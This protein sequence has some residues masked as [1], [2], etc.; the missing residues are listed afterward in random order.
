MTPG[1]LF[2]VSTPIG[3]LED[4]SLRAINCLKSCQGIAC[5]D[6]RVTQKLLNRYAI[7]QKLVSYRDAN[8]K[9]KALELLKYLQNGETWALVSDAGTPLINDPGFCLVRACKENNIPVVPIPGPCALIAALSAS[10]LPVH[11]FL[12]EGFLPPRSHGRQAFFKA[13]ASATY[14]VIAYESCHRIQAALQDLIATLGPDRVICVARELTKCH[15]S[16]LTGPA[17]SIAPQ[18]VARG[19]VVILIAPEGF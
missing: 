2:L 11:R 5:E 17:G 8:E 16:I 12:F 14:T 10:G 3:H 7:T 18:V 15:E 19:E 1:T 6:T 9:Q 4:F 13:H